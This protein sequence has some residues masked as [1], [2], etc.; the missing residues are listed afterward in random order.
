VKVG[1]LVAGRLGIA[2][3][4]RVWQSVIELLVASAVKRLFDSAGVTGL[5]YEPCIP[6]E[7]GPD[8][9][10]PPG[11]LAR[12][13]VRAYQTASDILPGSNRCTRHSVVTAPHLFDL[14]TPGDALRDSDFQMIDRVRIKGSDYFY[15][16]PLWVVARRVLELLLDNRIR[17]LRPAGWI[18][19][20]KF[21]PL[22]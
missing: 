1:N 7:E 6:S 11:Y 4:G 14:R 21:R 5:E 20:E 16:K 10:S 2:Q 13:V 22:V 12:L 19:R 18:L 8:E 17:G 3:I 9:L 15:Y